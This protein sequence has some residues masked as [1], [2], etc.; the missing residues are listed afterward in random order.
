MPGFPYTCGGGELTF[1][2]GGIAETCMGL[3]TR[4]AVILKL[5]E[6]KV[7]GEGLA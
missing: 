2:L 6:A 1:A 4:P 3:G 7:D 5:G